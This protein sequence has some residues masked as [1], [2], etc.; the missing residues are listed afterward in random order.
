MNSMSYT[1]E[2]TTEESVAE[3]SVRSA[4][5]ASYIVMSKFISFIIAGV[6]FVIVVRFLGPT[7]YGIYVLATAVVGVFGSVG[8]LGVS[9]AFNKL[10]AENRLGKKRVLEEILANGFTILLIAGIILTAIAIVVSSF[11]ASSVYH[12]QSF[13]APFYLISFSIMVS[14]LF[15]AGY[16]AL[17]GLG[18]GTN[19]A[20]P[21]II[22]AIFQY[23]ISIGLVV[24]GFGVF[25]P[26]LGLIFGLFAGFVA[27]MFIMR[28]KNRIG[29]AR[30]SISG[31]KKIFNF[32]LPIVISN[33]LGTV[34]N[35]VAILVLGLFVVAAVVGNIGIAQNANAL[36]SLVTVSISV[37]L[38]QLF[39]TV[40]KSNKA[41][42]RVGDFFSNSVYYA[43]VFVAPLIFFVTILAKPV[44]YVAFGGVYNLAPLYIR[45]TSMGLLLGLAG[46][47][48]TSLIISIGNT[49]Q[50]LKYNAIIVA[51]QLLLVFALIPILK[52]MGFML[53]FFVITPVLM[54]V[55]FVRYA[56]KKLKVGLKL[57]RL[58]RVLTAN[59]LGTLPL[60]LLII[61]FGGNYVPLLIVG[62]ITT[63][64]TYPLALSALKGIERK[65][66][67][68]LR[69][70]SSG[71]PV[72]S[73]ILGLLLDYTA[74]LL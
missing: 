1:Q 2:T 54:D 33:V 52:G 40:L 13:A 53:T 30:P 64:L 36:F 34:V 62:V 61:V 39:S 6:A 67:K 14:M 37:S 74:L 5:L 49:K 19:A 66:M 29:F 71:V 22:E 72:V 4:N 20:L 18:K 28:V 70:F 16:S 23:G 8:D 24:L 25:A 3:I 60:Y 32:G 65:D 41:K 51:V 59:I 15:G 63:L 21:V 50:V 68:N 38:I 42:H 47:Y 73:S 56:I 35:N 57:G 31:M 11:L 46:A 17:I 44:S 26:I 58:F 48:A 55:L 7:T 45:F 69:K 43:F 9:T 10:M 27:C 12:N